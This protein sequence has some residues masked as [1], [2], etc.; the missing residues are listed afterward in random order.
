MEANLNAAKDA[1]FAEFEAAHAEDITAIEKSLLEK[2]QE[3][4]ASVKGNG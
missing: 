2:K 1:F 4:K 3:L